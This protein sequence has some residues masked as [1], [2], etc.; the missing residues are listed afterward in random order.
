[1]HSEEYW[2]LCRARV[3]LGV[4]S[5]EE[6]LSKIG[7]NRDVVCN[8][9]R[10]QARAAKKIKMHWSNLKLESFL[11]T[12]NDV[13][14]QVVSWDV[15]LKVS[16]NLDYG[17]NFSVAGF[18][19]RYRKEKINCSYPYSCTSNYDCSFADRCRS[20]L[21]RIQR[22]ARASES[23]VWRGKT[24]YL[25]MSINGVIIEKRAKLLSNSK[26]YWIC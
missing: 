10:N 14:F 13:D 5:I 8:K 7:V 23:V 4:L 19:L 21:A 22:E 18:I 17:W 2:K 25:S 12:M 6:V 24:P 26:F 16:G 15:K 20:P 9:M 11:E 3:A 1:M